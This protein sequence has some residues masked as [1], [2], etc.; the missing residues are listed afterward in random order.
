MYTPCY[1]DVDN[2]VLFHSIYFC[3][4]FKLF[5]AFQSQKIK[6]SLTIPS[7]LLVRGLKFRCSSKFSLNLEL[8]E[9]Y[10]CQQLP[11]PII[12]SI[13][14]ALNGLNRARAPKHITIQCNFH[15]YAWCSLTTVS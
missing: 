6:K 12:A 2:T 7:R 13:N 5:F 15:L 11:F 1:E 9:V 10:R 3:G 14:Y 8:C 4:I